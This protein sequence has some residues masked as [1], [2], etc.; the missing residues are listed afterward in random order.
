MAIAFDS[1]TSWTS[2]V[3]T[4]KTYSHTCTG[5]NLM[6]F[7]WVNSSLWDLITGVTYN[8]VAMTLIQKLKTG[9]AV[10]WNYV[11]ALQNPA[12]GSNNVVITASLSTGIYGTSTSYTEV[13]QSVTMDAT[14]TSSITASALNMSTNL[15]TISD[16]CWT[17]CFT[18]NDTNLFNANSDTMR[19]TNNGANIF[20]SNWPKTPAGSKTMTQWCAWSGNAGV[21]MVSFSPSVSPTFIPRIIIF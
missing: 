13:T 6:L 10:S 9:W 17:L 19:G 20:D 3:W 1:I 5:N 21:I 16:N 4:S 14:A 11:Y 2:T 15:T 7:V 12:T 18:V 8:G